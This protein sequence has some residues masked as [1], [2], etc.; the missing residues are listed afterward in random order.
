[1]SVCSNYTP[2]VIVIGSSSIKESFAP[3]PAPTVPFYV[4]ANPG[5]H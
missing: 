5:L 2:G 4:L 3:P 1:M